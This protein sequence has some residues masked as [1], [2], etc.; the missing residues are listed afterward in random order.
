MAK[1][2]SEAYRAVLSSE[3]GGR[4][5]PHGAPVFGK[6]RLGIDGNFWKLRSNNIPTDLLLDGEIRDA[7]EGSVREVVR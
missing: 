7:P 1:S 6:P 4:R 3:V 5:A 2:N